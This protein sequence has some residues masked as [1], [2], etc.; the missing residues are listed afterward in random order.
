MEIRVPH[1]ERGVYGAL[2]HKIKLKK[3]EIRK[4]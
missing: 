3:F 4:L 1:A 2:P